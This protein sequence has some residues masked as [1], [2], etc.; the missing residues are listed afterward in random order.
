[1]SMSFFL[2]P[3]SALFSEYNK[4][5]YQVSGCIEPVKMARSVHVTHK[6]PSNKSIN[7]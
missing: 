2:V 4:N 6:R 7:N 5:N 3:L 1:M